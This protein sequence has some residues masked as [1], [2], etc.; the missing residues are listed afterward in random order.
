MALTDTLNSAGIAAFGI[1]MPVLAPQW[2]SA[3]PTK[4]DNNLSLSI[5]AN[6]WLAPLPGL[7]RRVD[8]NKNP[9]SV[10]LVKADGTLLSSTGML[11]TVFAQSYLRLCRLYAQVLE[12]ANANRPERDKALPFRPVPRYFFYAGTLADA[13]KSGEVKAGDDTGRMGE[14]T[15]YDTCGMPIDPIAVAAAFQAILKSQAVLKSGA[16]A[17]PLDNIAGAAFAGTSVVRLRLADPA[18]APF[19]NSGNHLTGITSVNTGTGLFTLDKTG[20]GGGSDLSGSI[21]LQAGTGASGAFPDEDR[22]LLVFGPATTGRSGQSFKPPQLPGG[23]TLTRDFFSIRVM[24]LKKYLLG[25]RPSSGSFAA[26]QFEKMPAVRVNEPLNLLTDGNDILAAGDVALSG[27][28]TESICVAQAIEGDF[29]VP[30]TTGTNAHWPGFPAPTGTPATGDLA[31]VLKKSFNPAAAFYT[32]A[33]PQIDVVLTVNGLPEAATVRVYPRKFIEDAKEARGDGAGGIVPAGGVLKLFL[34]DPLNLKAPD[35]T[36]TTPTAPVL[37]FDLIV[38][39]RN[40]KSRIYGNNSCPI[41][42]TNTLPPSG[43]TNPFGTAAKRGV[44]NAGILGLGKNAG[45]LPSDPLQAALALAG[46]SNPRDASRMPTMARRDLLVAGLASSKWRSVIAG[47]RLARETHSAQQRL[48]CPGGQGGR[49]TQITGIS[50]QNGQLAYDIAR[51][52]FRRSTNIVSR[53]IDLAGNNWNEP[54]ALSAPAIGSPATDSSGT[55]AGAVLQ[56]ISPVCETPELSALKSKLGSLPNTFSDLVDWVKNNL[57]PGSFASQ[58]NSTLDNLKTST[59]SNVVAAKRLFDEL[60]REVVASAYGRRDAQWALA[61]AIGRACRFIYIESPGFSSTLKT[62]STAGYAVDLISKIASRMSQASGLKLMI[63][64]PKYAD[65]AAGYE[66]FAA[67]E[68]EERRKIINDLPSAKDPDN[69]RVAAFHPIGFPGRFSRLEST[70]VIVDDVWAMVGSSTF[71]RRGLTFDG[72]SD[73]VFTDFDVIEG[74]SPNITAFRRQ[75]MASRLGIDISTDATAIPNPNW[76]RLRDGGEAFF[77]VREM[78]LNGGLG[79]IDLLWNGR[80][81]GVTP[82]DPNSVPYDLVNPDG[83]EFT[84]V[85]TGYLAAALALAALAGLSNSF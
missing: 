68:V 62:G 44:S 20:G 71:R 4:D 43:G 70:V 29:N 82:I 75:I 35:G 64:T 76:V 50:T 46:E 85:G 58:L 41:T 54:S 47:G 55:F 11:L 57:V 22:R 18:G 48:G 30:T 72:G 59:N 13:D 42:T 25:D 36:V 51:M 27:S 69:S 66:P 19:D 63:C 1:S 7:L 5:A 65:F 24:Q 28:P 14:L 39:Q 40:G 78:I 56:T 16:D 52:A 32:G 34:K 10:T 77:V 3:A 49:E 67:R 84:D 73:V 74:A 26:M 79:K 12:T 38:V 31:V 23:V 17:N 2:T 15:I 80:T 6:S 81:E 61:N 8:N 53:L 83:Q 60:Q 45:A 33:S 21:G 37:R 9:L